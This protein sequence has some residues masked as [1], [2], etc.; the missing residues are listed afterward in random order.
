[1]IFLR[2][3][4][5]FLIHSSLE[6]FLSM[7]NKNHSLASF[8]ENSNLGP[9]RLRGLPQVFWGHGSVLVPLP[10]CDV[11][12]LLVVPAASWPGRWCGSFSYSFKKMRI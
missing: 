12:V 8:V 7:D 4:L 11:G 3:G 1:M 10:F 2:S 9:L 6:F 5:Q